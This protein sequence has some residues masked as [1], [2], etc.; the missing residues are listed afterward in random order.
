MIV[1]VSTNDKKFALCNAGFEFILEI[2]FK[3]KKWVGGIG[4]T[5]LKKVGVL[6]LVDGEGS[7]LVRDRAVDA[8][9]GEFG[10]VG[11]GVGCPTPSSETT[12]VFTFFDDSGGD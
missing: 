7:R 10:G 4:G 5:R 12:G 3:E 1:D 9:N 2:G 6:L 8:V 11:S